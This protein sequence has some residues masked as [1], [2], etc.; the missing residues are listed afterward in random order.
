MFISLIAQDY[1]VN[2]DLPIL[3]WYSITCKKSTL[4]S[5]P[6]SGNFMKHFVRSTWN[7]GLMSMLF[8]TGLTRSVGLFNV[9][10]G[11]VPML[12]CMGVPPK[13]ILTWA[14][15]SRFPSPF[16]CEISRHLLYSSLKHKATTISCSL[17]LNSS[18]TGL[19]LCTLHRRWEH[20]TYFS[21]SFSGINSSARAS[22][23]KRW[24]CAICV[25]CKPKFTYS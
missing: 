20:V 8:Y 6:F 17:W 10:N 11:F 16:V 21:I 18:L 3:I 24:K 7:H 9:R 15:V 22:I 5:L 2:G 12:F 1:K 19:F 13:K 4:L 25:T 14:L 23:F